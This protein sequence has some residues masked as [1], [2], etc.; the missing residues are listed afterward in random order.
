MF[1][2][3]ILLVGLLAL[4]ITL[5]G[6]PE[7]AMLQP[8]HPAR[9]VYL[10]VFVTGIVVGGAL[11]ILIFGGWRTWTNMAA[12]ILAIGGIGLIT[13]HTNSIQYAFSRLHG[14]FIPSVAVS[15]SSGEVEL[16]RTWDGHYRADTLVNGQSIRL[17]V[18]TGASMVLIP[19]EE[20]AS[21]GIDLDALDYSMPVTTANGRSTVAPVMLETVEIG[22]IRAHDVAAAVAHPGSLKSGLLGMSFLEQLDE[23]SFRRDRL[24]LRQ[25]ARASVFKSAPRF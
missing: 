17:L 1:F 21:L 7:W 11:R 22:P 25:R 18:D 23:T 20:A 3:P 13:Q 19:H 24:I 15:N 12:W 8:D 16:R 5:G 14:E 9:L 4:A 2:W 6:P 10:T